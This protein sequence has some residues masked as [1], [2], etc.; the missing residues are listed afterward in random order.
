MKDTNHVSAIVS[1]DIFDKLTHYCWAKR[2]TKSKLV[3]DLL[4]KWYEDYVENENYYKGQ[5]LATELELAQAVADGLIS[6]EEA[7]L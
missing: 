6:A 7:G 2:T 5:G 3:R 4:E 1:T